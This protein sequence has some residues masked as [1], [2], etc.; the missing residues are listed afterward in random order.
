MNNIIEDIKNYCF[1]TLASN[2]EYD[3]NNFNKKITDIYFRKNNIILK[4]KDKKII[5]S[6][7]VKEIE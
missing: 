3:I 4:T 1:S 6:I 5:I 2:I 7:K